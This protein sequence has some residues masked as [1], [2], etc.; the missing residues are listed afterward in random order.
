MSYYQEKQFIAKVDRNDKILGKEER[1]VAHKKGILHRGF[2]LILTYKKQ[3]VLQHRKHSAF[4]GVFD[5][6]FSSHQLYI[7]NV[8]ETDLAAMY[9]TLQREWN[10]GRRDLMNQPKFLDKIYYK[11]KDPNSIFTEHEVDYIYIVET[12]VLPIP[13]FTFAYGFSLVKKEVLK[14]YDL[15]VLNNLPLAPWVK[16]IIADF[17]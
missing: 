6:S 17:I 10:L 14:S 9:R 16:K 3:L 11:A 7:N 8:L 1:W 4:D 13:N 2:T 12:K 15:K 5:L